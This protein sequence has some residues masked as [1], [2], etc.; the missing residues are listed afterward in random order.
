MPPEGPRRGATRRGAAG[1]SF[2]SSARFSGDAFRRCALLKTERPADTRGP[3]RR[4][5]RRRRFQ[6]AGLWRRGGDAPRRR[7]DRKSSS[8]E[9]VLATSRCASATTAASRLASASATHRLAIAAVARGRRCTAARPQAQQRT[10]STEGRRRSLDSTPRVAEWRPRL[11]RQYV[12]ASSVPFTNSRMDCAR[13]RRQRHSLS[14]LPPQ[15]EGSA[16][17]S[18]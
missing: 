13:H 7:L 2:F 8:I 18:N 14:G 5:P 16:V 15:N 4:R 1:R 17:L 9:Q 6:A 10:S 12:A 3:R 11:V